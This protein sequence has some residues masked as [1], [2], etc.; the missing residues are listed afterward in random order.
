M[1]VKWR[2]ALFL[3]LVA[4][5]TSVTSGCVGEIPIIGFDRE[6]KTIESMVSESRYLKETGAGVNRMS[7]SVVPVL[8]SEAYG[9][10]LSGLRGIRVGLGL[11]GSVGL[12]DYWKLG[13]NIGLGL[14]FTNKS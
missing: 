10:K 13:G 8:D 5:A 7:E 12:W 9:R 14:H 2:S 1:R 4:S 3:A 11:K 6:G